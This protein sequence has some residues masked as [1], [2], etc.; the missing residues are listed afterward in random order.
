VPTNHGKQDQRDDPDAEREPPKGSPTLRCPVAPTLRW[1]IAT[2]IHLSL[3]CLIS[4]PK[5]HGARLR[6]KEVPKTFT[7]DLIYHH[8][9]EFIGCVLALRFA[10]NV[11]NFFIHL[12]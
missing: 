4:T 2:A 8:G 9:G 3:S 5:G 11:G 7:Y 10:K 6:S 12:H 1:D